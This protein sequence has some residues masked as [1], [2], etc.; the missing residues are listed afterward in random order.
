M[1]RASD[2]VSLNI[3]EGSTGQSD[4]EFAK[5]LGY[6]IRSGIEVVGCLYLARRRM[7]I[8]DKDFDLVY[9]FA[10]RLIRRIQTLRNSIS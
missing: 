7:I 2:S 9:N 5:F 1:Q 6:L 10:N 4:P 3:A 8:S